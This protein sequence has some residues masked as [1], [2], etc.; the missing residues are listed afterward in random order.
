[1]ADFRPEYKRTARLKYRGHTIQAVFYRPDYGLTV[2]GETV[3]HFFVD[4]GAAVRAGKRH[5][6]DLHKARSNDT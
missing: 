4:T 1:M 6:D 5:I 3:G 2:D